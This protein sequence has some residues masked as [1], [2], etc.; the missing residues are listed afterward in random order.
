[1]HIRL[2]GLTPDQSAHKVIIRDVKTVEYFPWYNHIE[3]LLESSDVPRHIHYNPETLMFKYHG[4]EYDFCKVST[5][6]EVKS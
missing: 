1:M 4:T 3:F 6:D 5:M 2:H